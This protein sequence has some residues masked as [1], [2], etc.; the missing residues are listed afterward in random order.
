MGKSFGWNE[1]LA[2]TV[3]PIVQDAVPL[4]REAKSRWLTKWGFEPG[5]D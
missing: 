2:E 1:W 3:L 5:E 4:L